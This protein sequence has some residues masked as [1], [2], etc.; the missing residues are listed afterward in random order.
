MKIVVGLGNPGKKYTFNRHNIGFLFIDYMSQKYGFSI[1][2]LG[3]SSV[4]GETNIEGEKVI[5][6]KP[7]TFMNLSGEAVVSAASYYHV[8]PKDIIIVY[9]DVSLP[10]GS[11]RIRFKGSAGGHNGIKSIIYSLKDDVFPRIKIG[12]GSP[13]CPEFEMANWVLSDIPKKDQ[14]EI[15]K[16]IEQSASACIAIIKGENEE[17]VMNLYNK[18]TGENNGV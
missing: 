8:E 15:Y 2:K 17:N 5:F 11:V 16:A 13:P 3:F 7:Q 4:Y 14:E 18:R 6:L 10:S 1:S 9:D 12:I